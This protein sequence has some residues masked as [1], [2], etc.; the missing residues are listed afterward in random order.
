[1]R[2]NRGRVVTLSRFGR[3]KIGR[4]VPFG[5]AVTDS[6][7]LGA[8][9]E[10]FET[11]GQAS[12]GYGLIAVVGS[13]PWA[14]REVAETGDDGGGEQAVSFGLGEDLADIAQESQGKV[15]AG[16]R[17]AGASCRRGG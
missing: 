13:R 10:G 15:L 6:D 9:V 11:P 4:V 14:I 5:A 8:D 17:K 1:M 2:K 16:R 7:G 12:F 3:W